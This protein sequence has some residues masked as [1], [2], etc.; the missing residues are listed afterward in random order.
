MKRKALL[1]RLN[2]KYKYNREDTDMDVE[3]IYK[4]QT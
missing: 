3:P 4:R 2:A 1:L